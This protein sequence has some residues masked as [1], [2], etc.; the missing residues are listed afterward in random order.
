MLFMSAFRRNER[1]VIYLY[2]TFSKL[3]QT[4]TGGDMLNFGYWNKETKSPLEA[5]YTLSNII[6]DFA[7]LNTAKTIIDVGSGYSSPALQ[8]KLQNNLLQI[9]CININFQ[10]LKCAIKNSSRKSF[11]D[12]DKIIYSSKQENVLRNKLF[13]LNSTST[14]LPIKSN[15]IDR[16]IA[17][18]SAQ[19]F[20]P[21]K[22]FIEES[23]RILNKTG[24]LIIAMPI[25]NNKNQIISIPL[26]V[27]LGILALTWASEHYELEY[28]TSIIK[29]NRFL[30]KDIRYIGSNVYS[31][32]AKYY[33]QN[34]TR[35]KVKVIKEYSKFFEHILYK[36]LLKMNDVSSKGVIEY[37][38]IKA[39]KI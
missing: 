9:I 36:S 3:M 35:L 30:I 33:I 34:R 20:K 17:F 24:F 5:Q 18:E 32:L 13:H 6:G 29:S 21:F 2:N 11:K 10:Q 15:S 12:K 22:D 28:I 8:W 38:L 23:N 27:K 14:I 39:Q 37:I 25:I 19:H 26:F 4:T 16:I 1:D 7:S 31:P